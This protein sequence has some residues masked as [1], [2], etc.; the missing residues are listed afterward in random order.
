M[1]MTTSTNTVSSELVAALEDVWTAIQTQHPDTPDVIITFGAGAMKGGLKLGHFAPEAWQQG[2]HRTHELFVG[3]EGLQ[4]GAAEVLATLL[5]EA[6]HAAA[7]A[8]KIADTSRGGRYHNSNFRII[9]EEFGLTL[10]QDKTIGWSNTILGVSTADTYTDEIAALDAAITIYRRTGQPGDDDENPIVGGASPKKSGNG[11]A[12]RCE[13]GRTIR[14]AP[15]TLAKAPI[16]CGSCMTA[17]QTK[18]N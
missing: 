18:E 4:R 10:T 13:C 8:R 9:G 16:I 6:A 14:V 2:T 5:H 1:T 11:N 17:F 3:G 7:N 12:C 15:S